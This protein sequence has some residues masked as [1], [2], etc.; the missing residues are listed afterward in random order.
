MQRYIDRVQQGLPLFEE[1]QPALSPLD[2]Q[3]VR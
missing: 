3:M 2:N 1:E